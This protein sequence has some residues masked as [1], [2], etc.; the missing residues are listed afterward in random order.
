M[1]SAAEDEDWKERFLGSSVEVQ[2]LMGIITI[3]SFDLILT[4]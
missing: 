1:L 2:R 4:D 3:K